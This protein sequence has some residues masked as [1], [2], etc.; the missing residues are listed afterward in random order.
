MNTAEKKRKVEI[1][2]PYKAT[3]PDIPDILDELLG[4]KDFIPGVL[5]SKNSWSGFATDDTMKG[6]RDTLLIYYSN[7][8]KALAKDASLCGYNTDKG[9]DC[10]IIIYGS[11]F[12][13]YVLQRMLSYFFPTWDI[14]H[15]MNSKMVKSYEKFHYP[16]NNVRIY[17][18]MDAIEKIICFN[19]NLFVIDT[20]GEN[21]LSISMFLQHLRV[22]DNRRV[23]DVYKHVKS[24]PTKQ[25]F[26]L[27]TA[28][29]TFYASVSNLKNQGLNEYMAEAR[30]YMLRW[31]EVDLN[32]IIQFAHHD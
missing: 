29:G 27:R 28:N 25:K 4:Q 15:F 17:T 3:R 7:L 20:Y 10:S 2:M 23:V 18:I 22:D 12:H 21:D 11:N 30:N 16:P 26:A 32:P 8:I 5:M 24:I 9:K 31:N 14:Y 1:K 13:H 19:T 6:W